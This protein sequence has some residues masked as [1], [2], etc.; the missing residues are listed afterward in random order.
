[1]AHQ[2]FVRVYFSDTDAAGIV[3]HARYL[4][5]TEH[6]RTEIIRS[7]AE[8]RD[9]SPVFPPTGF[10]VR[11][12]LADFYRPAFLHDLLKIETTIEQVKK[13][14]LVFCQRVTKDSE[15][16]AL[17]R[18]RIASVDPHTRRPVPLE[19]RLVEDLIDLCS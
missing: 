1:M 15:E 6:A 10:V 11:S 12:L 7:L 18:V 19:R 9:M 5:F 3:Y 17:L 16:V 4:D 2:F 14:S 8:K 13:F